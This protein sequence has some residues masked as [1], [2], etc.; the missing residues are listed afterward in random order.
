MSPVGS[1]K[2]S[3]GGDMLRFI[4]QIF[5]RHLFTQSRSRPGRMTCIKCRAR[6]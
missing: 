2:G 5:C 6:R 1:P 3:G 4:R